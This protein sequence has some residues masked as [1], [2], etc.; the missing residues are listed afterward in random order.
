[1]TKKNPALSYVRNRFDRLK[2]EIP[3][4]DEV[5]HP[6]KQEFAKE[7]NI[8]TI[9]AKARAGV[10]PRINSRT[11]MY[12]DFSNTP[13]TF[14][15]A[16]NAVERA[17]QNFYALPLEFRKELDHD[18]RNLPYAPKELFAK[19]GLLKGSASAHPEAS[20]KPANSPEGPQAT[21]P[22][23]EG[24]TPNS[25]APGAKKGGQKAPSSSSDES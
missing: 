7:A 10:A 4:H 21:T 17:T 9:I 2:V 11:P 18:P 8:N 1:M 24:Q 14:T 19:H 12:G 5:R 13:T 3:I 22:H 25:A 20:R 23:G 16:F 15:E 6:T